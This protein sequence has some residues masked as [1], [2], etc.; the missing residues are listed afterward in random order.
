[1]QLRRAVTRKAISRLDMAMAT[2][3]TV[4]MT[5]RGAQLIAHRAVEMINENIEAGISVDEDG[6]E[7]AFAPYSTRPFARP[8]GGIPQ[9]ALKMMEDAN[10]ITRFQTAAGKQ[11]IVVLGGYVVLKRAIN[12]AW[13]G[14]VDLANS[15]EMRRQIAVLEA[16]ED[17]VLIGF[18][19]REAAERAFFVSIRRPFM[20]LTTA[21]RDELVGM[22]TDGSN[23][24]FDA[25]VRL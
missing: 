8:A 21:Q 20:G 13:S 3:I 24:S 4:R 7:N 11:W 18:L 10:E 5:P 22:L 9:T 16:N 19:S 23:I 1:M 12:P 25:L 6:N 17:R 14:N 2:E 15:G